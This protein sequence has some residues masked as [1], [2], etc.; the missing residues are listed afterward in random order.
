M[1]NLFRPF[2]KIKK[3]KILVLGDF[4]LDTYTLGKVRRISPEAPVAVLNVDREEHR[5]GMTGNVALNMISMGADV[6][7]V[8][9][10]G[11]DRNGEILVKAL[12][13]EGVDCTGIIVQHSYPTPVKNR[14]IAD[15]QQIVRVDHELL[16]QVPELLEQQVIEILSSL[17]ENVKLIAI[18]DYGKGFVTRSLISFVVDLAK[19]NQIPVIVDPKGLDFTKYSGVDLLKPNLSEVYAAA[20]LPLDASIEMAAQRILDTTKIQIL[21]VTRSEAGISLFEQDGSHTNFPV[22]IREVKDVTGA[23]D[24]VLAMLACALA[25]GL[26][27]VEAAQLSNLAAGIAI[28]KFGCARVTLSEL[29]RRLLS[30]DTESK[31]F[32]AEH[33]YV[34]QEALKGRRFA[35]LSLLSSEG[36]NLK[37][38]SAIREI[39]H[40]KNWDLLVYVED[41]EPDPVFIDAVA[42]LHDVDYIII[43]SVGI[44]DLCNVLSPDE[45]FLFD[46]ASGIQLISG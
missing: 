31:V 29:A 2:S 18:S 11:D 27:V 38:F 22:R 34:L 25:N 9:R 42:A 6:V 16:C 3:Q 4:V 17:L 26:S 39:A 21:M 12:S 5:P 35:L 33:L 10:V 30:D 15:N 45:V 44:N 37:M 43:K 19:R 28:E 32:D 14:I 23:G 41:P 1:V 8:G 46:V 7:A 24:T 20:N 13:D 40:K 36:F